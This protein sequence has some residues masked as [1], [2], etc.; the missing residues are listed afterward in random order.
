MDG[1]RARRRP[2]LS[3]FIDDA[4]AHAAPR[5]PQ[6]EREPAGSGARNQDV[7][8]GHGILPLLLRKGGRRRQSNTGAIRRLDACPL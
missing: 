4:H 6:R 3:D 1:E 5:E 2:W 7:G 8:I